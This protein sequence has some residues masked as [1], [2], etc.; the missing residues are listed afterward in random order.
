MRIVILHPTIPE[1][2]TLEDQDSLVQAEAISQS[3][4]APGP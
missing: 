4:S 1:G 3:L 2:A